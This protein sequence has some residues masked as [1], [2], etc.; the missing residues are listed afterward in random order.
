MRIKAAR[1]AMR[2]VDNFS[3][4]E[5]TA[6]G[7]NV[8][9]FLEIDGISVAEFRETEGLFVFVR[10]GGDVSLGRTFQAKVDRKPIVVSSQDGPPADR[11]V[12][13]MVPRDA[14]KFTLHFGPRAPIAFT[15]NEQIVPVIR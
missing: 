13:V 12:V 5:T 15:A 2:Y 9:L 7:T 14:L 6:R 4:V 10:P 1:R 3:K 8:I 11:R